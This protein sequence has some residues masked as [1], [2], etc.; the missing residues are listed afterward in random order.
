MDG[1]QDIYILHARPWQLMINLKLSVEQV[2][3]TSPTPNKFD[4]PEW[5]ALAR[6]S[7][8][9]KLNDIPI[10]PCV[11]RMWKAL[12]SRENK[13]PLQ[14]VMVAVNIQS[15]LG[16]MSETLSKKYTVEALDINILHIENI[17]NRIEHLDETC[18][19][20]LDDMNLANRDKKANTPETYITR[21][22][23]M[24]KELTGLDTSICSG[25]SDLQD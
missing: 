8:G 13:T 24:E 19:D 22:G 3:K 25:I 20:I 17:R 7:V 21:L 5:D 9:N 18:M 12:F 23:Q 16:S 14:N 10:N 11:S 4:T 1:Y 2:A 15:M 6:E